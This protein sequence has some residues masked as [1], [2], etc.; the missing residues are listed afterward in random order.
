MRDQHSNGVLDLSMSGNDKKEGE[1]EMSE[2]RVA[3]VTGASR[4]IGAAIIVELAYAGFVT[5]GI[6]QNGS[7]D[8]TA[9]DE[10]LQKIDKRNRLLTC[11]TADRADVAETYA[12]IQED[13][14]VVTDL[15][16]CAGIT[17][18]S[19]LA[20]MSG[21][22]WDQVMATNLTGMFNLTNQFTFPAMKNGF[23]VV[24]NI[25]SIAGVQ[26][27]RGQTNYAASKAGMDG[28]TRSLAKEV[29]SSNIRVN[30]VAPGFIDTDLTRTFSEKQRKQLARSVSLRRLGTPSDIGKVV[31]FL[32]SDDASYITGQTLVVDGGAVI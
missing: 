15:V 18:D 17:R 11:N 2:N 3:V 13:C 9:V 26:G 28:F 30:S 29:G 8:A 31:R 16:N 20:L 5:I 24:T 21:E 14:G 7:N 25:S 12:R 10:Q 27:N 4:G 32:H 23:G 19:S 6:H 1:L 22:Q